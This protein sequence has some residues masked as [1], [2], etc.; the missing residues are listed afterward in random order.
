LDVGATYWFDW[1]LTAPSAPVTPVS[2]IYFDV[3]FY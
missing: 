1:V 3:I 2:Y